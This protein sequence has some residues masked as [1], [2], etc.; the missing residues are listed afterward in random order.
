MIIT[1]LR[2]IAYHYITPKKWTNKYT[3]K[4]VFLRSEFI[5]LSNSSNTRAYS[6]HQKGS[7]DTRPNNCN[8]SSSIYRVTNANL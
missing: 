4:I 5:S 6:F 7:I 3:V 2:N 8:A 1:T